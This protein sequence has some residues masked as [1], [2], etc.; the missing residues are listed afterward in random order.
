MAEA[1]V[2][3]LAVAFDR[4]DHFVAVQSPL[5]AGDP[6]SLLCLWEAVGVGAPERALLLERTREVASPGQLGGVALG[7]LIGLFAMQ[8]AETPAW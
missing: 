3:N 5:P 7:V 2:A 4:I 8:D 6:A 1:L